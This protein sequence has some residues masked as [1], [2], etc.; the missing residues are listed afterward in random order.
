MIKLNITLKF[1]LCVIRD[2]FGMGDYISKC[3]SFLYLS[4]IHS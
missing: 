1:I 2:E 3:V 4:H